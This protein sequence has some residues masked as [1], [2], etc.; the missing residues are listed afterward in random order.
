[1]KKFL[2][3]VAV[4][5]TAMFATAQ[6]RTY[7]DNLVVIINGEV[8]DQQTSEITLEKEDGG[9][10]KLSLNHFVLGGFMKIGNIVIDNIS[11]ST[12]DG[13]EVFTVERNIIIEAG[14]EN[15]DDW[16]G[17]MLG[18]VPVDITGKMTEHKLYCNIDIDMTSTLGQVIN[19]KFGQE[20]LTGI[21]DVEVEEGI[22]AIHDLTGRRID[23]I[24]APGIYIIDGKKV[25]VK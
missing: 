10:Y 2:L 23:A 22:K 6:T 13:I 7:T 4:A 14:D 16:M 20:D 8:A 3:T 15:T 18:E 24:T 9:T 17:P 1:M 12:Q 5:M 19:V 25:L 21:E 11:V